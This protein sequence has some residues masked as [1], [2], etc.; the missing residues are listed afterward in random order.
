MKQAQPLS[1][2]HNRILAILREAD[3]AFVPGVK[4]CAGA[5]IPMT[6]LSSWV[7]QIRAAHPEMVIEGRKGSGYRVVSRGA[8]P[9][10][11]L[12]VATIHPG[13]PGAGVPLHRRMA[14]NM[15][16]L[17]LL[18]AKSAELVK[19]VAIETG[20]DTD[21]TL[22]RLIS[23]GVEVHNDLVFKGENPIALRRPKAGS[24]DEQVL[25]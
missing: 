10:E 23:Y 7:A 17:D 22:H 14:A 4:L 25:H 12:T 9:G 2:A 8:E 18:P 16:V 5:S 6:L 21:A 20:E 11:A 3:G 15:A 13:R 24:R 19:L 1:P